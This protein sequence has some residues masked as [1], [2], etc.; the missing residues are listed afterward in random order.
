MCLVQLQGPI[1]GS[2]YI[3]YA[4]RSGELTFE[5]SRVPVNVANFSYKCDLLSNQIVSSCIPS[6]LIFS[7]ISGCDCVAN[8]AS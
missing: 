5:I 4:A 7:R 1:I 2:T 3:L 6:W 8:E